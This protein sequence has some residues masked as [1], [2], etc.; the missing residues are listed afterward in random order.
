MS[1]IVG[2]ISFFSVITCNCQ[3]F[4]N[5]IVFFQLLLFSFGWRFLFQCFS[6][7]ARNHTRISYYN[8]F[9]GNGAIRNRG[10]G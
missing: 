9:L 1:F 8:D 2:S 4:A 7:K 3:V 6:P 10:S 5:L